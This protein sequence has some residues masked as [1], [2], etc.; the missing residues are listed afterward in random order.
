MLLASY[1]HL[2]ILITVEALGSDYLQKQYIEDM[3]DTFQE[4][5]PP[6]QP[7]IY[8]CT[9]MIHYR[10]KFICKHTIEIH[11]TAKGGNKSLKNMN[12]KFC[13]N[14]SEIFAPIDGKTNPKTILIEGVSGIG[15]TLL[16]RRITSDWK[17]ISYFR[18]KEY[19]FLL[20][21]WNPEVNCISNVHDMI[22]HIFKEKY[23]NR[24]DQIKNYICERNGS[25]LAIILDSD[26]EFYMDKHNSFFTDLIERKV[27][28]LSKCL[29]VITSQPSDC[30][31]LQC[32]VCRRVEM[33]GFIEDHKE[34]L[35]TA[36]PD[37]QVLR[38][39]K[40]LKQHIQNNPSID[41]LCCIPLYLSFL[42]YLL[43]NNITL[44]KTQTKFFE[45]FIC[46][47]FSYCL[48]L[49]RFDNMSQL[50]GKHHKIIK[51]LGKYSFDLL[52]K[53]KFNFSSEDLKTECP[54]YWSFIGP[55]ENPCSC[56]L[57]K[58]MQ[59]FP[60]TEVTY[61]FIHLRVQEYLAAYHL[62][63]PGLSEMYRTNDILKNHFLKCG[64]GNMWIL[65]FGI[66]K[67]ERGRGF[68]NHFSRGIFNYFR[69]ENTVKRNRDRY[70]SPDVYNDQLKCLQ[71]FQC[72]KEVNDD[73]MCTSIRNNS[74]GDKISF[75]GH[76][77]L[78]ENMITLCFVITQPSQYNNLTTLDLTDCKIGDSGCSYFYQQL[79]YCLPS[80]GLTINELKLS[81]NQLTPSS[82]NHIIE[83]TLKLKITALDL[84][85]NHFFDVEAA[86]LVNKCH[87]LNFL[88]L[89]DNNINNADEQSENIF[90]SNSRSNM[91]IVFTRGCLVFHHDNINNFTT[92]NASVKSLFMDHTDT[93][94]NP[95]IIQFLQKATSLKVLHLRTQSNFDASLLNFNTIKELYANQLSDRDANYCIEKLSKKSNFIIMITSKSKFYASYVQN[96]KIL[97]FAL[98]K[99]KTQ[100]ICEIYMFSCKFD[101]KYLAKALT[102]TVHF[103]FVSIADC[104]IGDS[105]IE[106]LYR[107]QHFTTINEFCLSSGNLQ[108]VDYLKKLVDCWQLKKLYIDNHPLSLSCI[109]EITIYIKN[110][111]LELEELYMHVQNYDCVVNE[112]LDA[113][114]ECLF[115]DPKYSVDLSVI[116]NNSI[117]VKKPSDQNE[118][119]IMKYMNKNKFSRLK[120]YITE[121]NLQFNCLS[122]YLSHI[123]HDKGIVLEKLYLDAK[124]VNIE[125]LC[126]ILKNN[127]Q[128]ME[129]FYLCMSVNALLNEKCNHLLKSYCENIRTCLL[130]ENMVQAKNFII[131]NPVL[132]LLT[133]TQN[134]TSI[135]FVHC[136][137]SRKMVD[138][139]AET[140]VTRIRELSDVDLSHCNLGD[141]GI[142][143]IWSRLQHSNVIS[144][145]KSLNLSGNNISHHSVG[146]LIDIVSFWQV[147]LFY[148]SDNSLKSQGIHQ[149]IAYAM[150]HDNITYIELLEIHA[151][152][153]EES[154]EKT[155]FSKQIQLSFVLTNNGIV[156][157]RDLC[158]ISIKRKVIIERLYVC[159][160]KCNY[161]LN[162]QQLSSILNQ[163]VESLKSLCIINHHS[164]GIEEIKLQSFPKLRQVYFEVMSLSDTI[165]NQLI[166][167]C[168][169]KE[170]PTV[171]ISKS[172]FAAFKATEDM[173]LQALNFCCKT[174][175][176]TT[177]EV[178]ESKLEK[179]L[180]L[181]IGIY[182]SNCN[183]TW[184]LIC[185][186]NCN[187]LDHHI[188]TLAEI[189]NSKAT[190][191]KLD[192]SSNKLKSSSFKYL[193]KVVF[194]WKTRDLII[195]ENSLSSDIIYDFSNFITSSQLQYLYMKRNTELA[196]FSGQILCETIVFNDDCKVKFAQ[197]TEDVTFINWSTI[198]NHFETTKQNNECS[199]Y[200]KVKLFQQAK[201]INAVKYLESLFTSLHKIKH[202]FIVITDTEYFYDQFFNVIVKNTGK[203]QNLLVCAESMP[204][205]VFISLMSNN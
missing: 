113:I 141:V 41:I 52:T 68:L 88:S 48:K 160:R 197:V 108:S 103:N 22:E 125:I 129:C 97:N 203:I 86:M 192:L 200:F 58:E 93:G 84:S 137:F 204:E 123:A 101:I 55:Y 196:N 104:G 111:N 155:Y 31:Q 124:Q 1:V 39:C 83:L 50:V 143:V 118:H 34:Y 140:L 169:M 178:T 43:E 33:L 193:G 205:C 32:H 87:C 201:Y 144:S 62:T 153:R 57:L 106:Y 95:Q 112:L 79:Q 109:E 13:E 53:D 138:Y 16:V 163:A 61:S 162:F 176:V 194:M 132:T 145:V 105:E 44:P 76:H 67:E 4:K 42:V 187:L 19:V 114:C 90:Y 135:S 74:L 100:S 66:T 172:K 195:E 151:A 177:V 2:C 173:I 54:T 126:S 181:N 130:S 29:I 156:I 14:V 8:K 59:H 69:I 189:T 6:N 116:N 199:I 146:H 26:K 23:R 80:G 191:L 25:C 184:E 45:K 3:H 89:V 60:S 117:I 18:K 36:F 47:T 94:Y 148:A 73:E 166:N 91:S 110:E 30:K 182:I 21:L 152:N 17:N 202:L 102:S 10:E 49:G 24:I 77:M 27:A 81:H 12:Q 167:V 174:T 134:I 139:L 198:D 28:E 183:K 161:N 186:R 131:K 190:V 165:A 92:Y 38:K 115:L 78:P 170:I 159:N 158:V 171:I 20:N 119:S 40:E 150:A 75:S 85:S 180:I 99:C 133:C 11:R 127:M 147:H 5:W 154:W 15:K 164:T 63:Q 175:S 35:S 188:Q 51:E 64:Y 65:Y 107:E 142:E 157:A 136:T 37:F 70:I 56:G 149:F 96:S 185:L 72:F 9:V 71:L 120:L 98:E 122:R 46:H 121:S 179:Q 168:K 7:K 128:Q 82:V